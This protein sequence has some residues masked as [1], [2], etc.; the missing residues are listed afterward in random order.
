MKVFKYENI[1]FNNN[2]GS[3]EV[4]EAFLGWIGGGGA[5]V[6]F[7]NLN[8]QGWKCP[9]VPLYLAKTSSQ[10]F[11][12]SKTFKC[13]HLSNHWSHSNTKPY[14]LPF[15][16]I[17]PPNIF[18]KNKKSLNYEQNHFIILFHLMEYNIFSLLFYFFF[19]S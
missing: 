6:T 13:M 11:V 16:P 2:Q 12:Y 3:W 1:K 18:N 5:W 7:K 10:C 9:L 8:F 15:M 17:P 4:K 14:L 19:L